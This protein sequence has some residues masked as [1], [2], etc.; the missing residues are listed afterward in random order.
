M[1]SILKLTRELDEI[2]IDTELLSQN[3]IAVEEAMLHGEIVI[4]A[5]AM[6]LPN[7]ALIDIVKR[8]RKTND[9]FFA[10][11]KTLNKAVTTD[12]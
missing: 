9:D 8:L 6:M 12:E 5:E 4:T 3:L 2:A 7:N 10:Y 1:S 11:V